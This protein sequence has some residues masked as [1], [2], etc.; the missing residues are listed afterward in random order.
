MRR[1]SEAQFVVFTLKSFVQDLV[2]S[3][4]KVFHM[5]IIAGADQDRD[6]AVDI[7]FVAPLPKCHLFHAL[8]HAPL[9]ADFTN[10]GFVSGGHCPI[11][12]ASPKPRQSARYVFKG[13]VSY[14]TPGRGN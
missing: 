14:L 12:S 10:G 6:P 4:I 3:R 5:A 1:P 7:S 13:C 8:S 9:S 2:R 11:P